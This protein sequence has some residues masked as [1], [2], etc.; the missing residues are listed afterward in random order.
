M[1][2]H[3]KVAGNSCCNRFTNL[4]TILAGDFQKDLTI[5]PPNFYPK[6]QRAAAMG[7]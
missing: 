2:D 6:Q 4:D 1:R 3:P 5:T 7:I